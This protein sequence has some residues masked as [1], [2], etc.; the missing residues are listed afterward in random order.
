MENSLKIPKNIQFLEDYNKPLFNH[1]A[2]G[3]W[4]H[5]RGKDTNSFGGINPDLNLQSK[6]GIVLTIYDLNYPCQILLDSN[7]GKIYDC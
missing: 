1:W 2:Y 5:W 7:R 3:Y 4:L 6:K